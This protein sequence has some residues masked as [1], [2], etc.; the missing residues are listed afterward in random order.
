MCGQCDEMDR[1]A[2]EEAERTAG[3]NGCARTWAMAETCLANWIVAH[4]FVTG[5]GDDFDALLDELEWQV[6]E[7]RAKSPVGTP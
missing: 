4:G 7:L 2:N 6:A 5:H 3:V 1:Q